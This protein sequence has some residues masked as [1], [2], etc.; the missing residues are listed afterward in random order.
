MNQLDKN[1]IR[2]RVLYSLSGNIIR[3]GLSFLTGILIAKGMGPESFGVFGFLLAS[4]TVLTQMLDLGSS[5]AFSTFMSKRN[6]SASYLIYYCSWLL[7]QFIA[8]FVFIYFL[9]PD[10]VVQ[11]L[12]Q[13]EERELVTI[14]FIAVFMQQKGWVTVSQ[15]GESQRFTKHV[16]L[17]SILV[18]L[19]HFIIISILLYND[20]ITVRLIYWI[21]AAEFALGIAVVL[22]ILPM[23]YAKET[24]SFGKILGEYK[25][26]CL[27]LIP[28]AW[29]MIICMFGDTWLLQFY[30][31]SV[32]QAF[33]AVAM[34]F[35]VICLIAT[36]SILSIL[37]KEVAEAF[38]EGDTAKVRILFSSSTR[39]LHAFGA[40]IA[41]FLIPWTSEIIVIS[42]GPEYIAG[43]LAMAIMFLYP[44][45][46]AR[47][48]VAGTMLLAME[49]TK[50]TLFIGVV[51]NVLGLT[52]TYFLVASPTEV[53]PGL[54]LGSTGLALKMVLVQ[55]LT[56]NV[57]IW[58]VSKTLKIEG[59]DLY[60]FF[61]IGLFLSFGY[62]SNFG[63]NYI[64][65]DTFGFIFKFGLSGVMYT[66]LVISVVYKWHSLFLINVSQKDRINSF[67]RS[68]L[69]K[70]KI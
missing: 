49:M 61:V 50:V 32:E 5:S 15:I 60:Q 35:S 44:I 58:W 46:Q 45:D 67:L 36:R 65:G 6:R 2:G 17:V 21:I 30:G 33:Y 62:I 64:V 27:P 54:G 16:Q 13:G 12:W 52:V 25:V 18:A 4:F 57:S 37:W 11:K 3:A 19:A 20:T 40:F 14:A 69:N 59:N 38:S 47:G 9:A 43:S 70:T 53:V 42:L 7:I 28:N 26:Y 41:C 68:V 31:G 63:I 10:I 48:Q 23:Q 34:Q 29:I 22:Y 51:S 39:W 56:V 66:L 1:N 55:F 8:L 24:E